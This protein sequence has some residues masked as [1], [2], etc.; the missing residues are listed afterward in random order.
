MTT[1]K[2]NWLRPHGPGWTPGPME[3]VHDNPWFAVEVHKVKAPTGVDADYFV[4][5][6]KNIAVGVLPLHADGRV[7]LVGQWRF[8]KGDYSWELPEGGAPHDEDPLDGAKRELAEEAG[9]KAGDWRKILTMQLSNA[10]SDEVCLGYLA[11]D[12]QPVDTDF[13]PTE[14][15]TAATVPYREAL[16]AA[17]SGVIQDSITVAMLL[18]LHHMAYEGQLPDRLARAILGRDADG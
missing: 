17:I 2:P 5:R 4:Q 13:D 7:T 15:L 1:Q 14:A 10:S 3:E 16:D 9:L 11:M 8:P 18:R 12:L 6:Y